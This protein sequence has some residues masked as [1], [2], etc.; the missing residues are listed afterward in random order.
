V[1]DGHRMIGSGLFMVNT[2]WGVEDAL[3]ELA[4]VFDG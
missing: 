1:R 3:A 2:P 4:R